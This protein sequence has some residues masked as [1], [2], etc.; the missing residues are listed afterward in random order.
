M[1]L[2]SFQLRSQGT[3]V[4]NTMADLLISIH[5]LPSE[6]RR[7]AAECARE[8]QMFMAEVHYCP[9]RSCQVTPDDILALSDEALDTMPPDRILLTKDVPICSGDGNQQLLKDNPCAL[10][11][12]IGA[13]DESGLKES[14]LMA[15]CEHSSLPSEWKLIAKRLRQISLSGAKCVNAV[16]GASVAVNSHRFSP[17]AKKL[18]ETGVQMLAMGGNRVIL[19]G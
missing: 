3:D 13:F 8:H 5:V 4:G 11:F 19:E 10:V 1:A 14:A 15:R 18:Q 6:L 17:R 9:F 7:F 16:S 2:G 12:E